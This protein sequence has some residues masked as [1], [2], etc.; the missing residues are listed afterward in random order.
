MRL[1]KDTARVLRMMGID[2]I[3]SDCQD[4]WKRALAWV[5]I[6]NPPQSPKTINARVFCQDQDIIRTIQE[7]D[8]SSLHPSFKKS[9]L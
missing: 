4:W 2:K 8:H 5:E 3:L 6:E 1:E 9:K 7:E